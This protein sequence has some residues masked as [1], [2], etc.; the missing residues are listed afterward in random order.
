MEIKKQTV[1]N[2]DSIN[3]LVE[4]GVVENVQGQ[5]IETEPVE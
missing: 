2:D 4:E 5:T 1:T 3:E